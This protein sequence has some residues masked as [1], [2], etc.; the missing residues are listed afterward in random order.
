MTK[1]KKG[2]GPGPLDLKIFTEK[3]YPNM[4]KAVTDLSYLLDRNYTETSALKVVGDRYQLQLRQRQACLRGSA[5]PIA[6]QKRQANYTEQLAGQTLAIDCFNLTILLEAAIGGGALFIG[7]D[8]CI[9]DLSSI[10]GNYRLVTQTQKVLELIGRHLEKK[11]VKEVFWW[12]D[13]PVSNSGRLA[14]LIREVA[15]ANQWPWQAQ[16]DPQV[17]QNLII[18]EH[19]V[20]S[21]DKIILEGCQRWNNLGRTLIEEY[22]PEAWTIDLKSSID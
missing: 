2:R 3:H 22:I 19:I 12:I 13:K 9:R 14:G 16:T 8:G 11:Q 17:D 5:G 7:S 10:H 18:S 21:T 15:E 20:V 1:E 4:I 6:I